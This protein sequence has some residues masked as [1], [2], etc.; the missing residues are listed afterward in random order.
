[1]LF[2]I[3]AI[4]ER[5]GFV[6]AAINGGPGR[7]AVVAGRP[8]NNEHNIFPLVQMNVRLYRNVDICPVS[9]CDDFVLCYYMDGQRYPSG[10]L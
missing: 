2:D 3:Y 4:P 8:I 1:M 5:Q 7:I 6:L 9:V 10:F